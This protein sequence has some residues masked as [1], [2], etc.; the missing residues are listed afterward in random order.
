MI[1]RQNRLAIRFP[2]G[3]ATPF[4]ESEF[5]RGCDFI[6]WDRLLAFQKYGENDRLEAYPTIFSQPLRGPV[7]AKLRRTGD[8]MVPLRLLVRS[9][10]QQIRKASQGR[11]L[12]IR[13]RS[14]RRLLAW[15]PFVSE[16]IRS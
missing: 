3:S 1:R 13:D 6:G 15:Q 16:A 8:A 14:S 5:L 9:R 12:T 11:P 2:P 7:D 4:P 10:L